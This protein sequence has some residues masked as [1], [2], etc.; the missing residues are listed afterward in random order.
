MNS[1]WASGRMNAVKSAIPLFGP[2]TEAGSNVRSSAPRRPGCI[3]RRP[4]GSLRRPAQA[5]NRDTPARRPEELADRAAAPIPFPPWRHRIDGVFL[6]KRDEPIQV[7]ALPGPHITLEQAPLLFIGHRSLAS[8]AC[9][10]GVASLAR[11]RCRALFTEATEASSTAADL[12][13]RPTHDVGQQQHRPLTRRQ[14]LD[15]D[16]EREPNGLAHLVAGIWSC[17]RVGKVFQLGV[18]IRLD[19]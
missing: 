18:G 9:R 13:R 15:R 4:V 12:D 19:P 1:L 8:V 6:Q 7:R 5:E 10:S 14:L 11:A 3:V 17:S 16:D 2:A